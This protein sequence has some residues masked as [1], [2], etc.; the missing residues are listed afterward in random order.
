MKKTYQKPALVR[1][2]QLSKVT[3]GPIPSDFVPAPNG[4]GPVAED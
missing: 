4:G 2:E 3:A 1:R